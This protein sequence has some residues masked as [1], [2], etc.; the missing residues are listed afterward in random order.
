MIENNS[1]AN[2]NFVGYLGIKNYSKVEQNFILPLVYKFFYSKNIIE[3]KAIKSQ[4]SFADIDF[5]RENFENFFAH[6]Y[7]NIV[8][9]IYNLNGEIIIPVTYCITLDKENCS[10]Q[11]D[12]TGIWYDEILLHNQ[13]VFYFIYIDIQEIFNFLRTH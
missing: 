10:Q 13:P 1:N 11:C 3:F 12:I 6:F 7:E 5:Q 4:A 8:N 9:D 2:S